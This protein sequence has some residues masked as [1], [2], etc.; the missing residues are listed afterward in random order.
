MEI[1]PE[2]LKVLADKWNDADLA[3]AEVDR[4]YP[5][6][7]LDLK[8]SAESGC[9]SRSFFCKNSQEMHALHRR[10]EKHGFTAY[11]YESGFSVLVDWSGR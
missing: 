5:Q 6:A 10:F 11:S 9:Y 1:N 8:K 4:I 2:T 3:E 7:L